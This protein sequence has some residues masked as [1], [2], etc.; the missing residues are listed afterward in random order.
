MHIPLF[1]TENGSAFHI[2]NF[3]TTFREIRTNHADTHITGQSMRVDVATSAAK[4]RIEY[5]LIKSLISGL[6]IL[7][8]DI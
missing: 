4:A 6:P 2:C 7:T 1:L 8:C 3:L 5:N